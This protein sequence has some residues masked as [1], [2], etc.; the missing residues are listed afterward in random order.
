MRYRWY[1][2]RALA[3]AMRPR[4]GE[5]SPS[6]ASTFVSMRDRKNDATEVMPV[7]GSPDYIRTTRNADVRAS[8]EAA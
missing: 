2:T 7:S 1:A 4:S 5:P 6:W 3:T 8:G